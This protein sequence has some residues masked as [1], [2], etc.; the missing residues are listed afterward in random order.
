[1]FI[2]ERGRSGPALVKKYVEMHGGSIWLDSEVDKGRYIYVHST[3]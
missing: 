3:S 2:I 1:M